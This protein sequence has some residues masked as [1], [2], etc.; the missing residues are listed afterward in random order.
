MGPATCIAKERALPQTALAFD[1]E[2]H[3]IAPGLAAPPLVCVSWA[4]ADR[5]GLFA[6][7]E[8]LRFLHAALVD[9]DFL[10]IGHN[11]AY[12]MAVLCAAGGQPMIDAVFTA[13]AADR[14]R[15]TMIRAMLLSIARGTFAFERKRMGLAALGKEHL[16]VDLDKGE[17]TWR[18][19]YSELDNMPIAVWPEEARAYALRDGRTTFDLFTALP[20]TAS[21]FDEG[22]QVR[23]A[24]ALQ[25]MTVW[26]LRTDPVAVQKLEARL[27]GEQQHLL[28]QLVPTGWIRAT[29]VK[30]TKVLRD[31]VEAQFAVQGIQ[32]PRTAPSK[33]FPG[34]QIKINEETLQLINDPRFEPF[35]K[36]ERNKKIL[37]TFIPVVRRGTQ[38]P[39]NPR[40][41][42]AE[43]GRTTCSKGEV[44]DRAGKKQIVGANVQQLPRAKGVR[45]CFVPRPGWVFGAADWNSAELCALA[46]VMFSW[47][48]FSKM[49]IAI[50]KGRDLHVDLASELL[51]VS[52]EDAMVRKAAGDE[53]IKD[54]RQF[55]KIGNFGLAGGMGARTFVIHARGKGHRTTLEKAEHLKR[56]WK[57]KWGMNPYFD[58]IGELTKETGPC[59]IVQYGSGR[60][61]GRLNFPQ[62]ANTFFQGLVADAAK[63][64]LFAVAVAC[65]HDRTSPMY[66][67]RPVVFAH[68]EVI[69]E[70]PEAQAAAATDELSRIMNAEGQRWM[71]DVPITSEPA[72]M[73]RW[74]KGAK[75]IRDAQGVL[76]VYE[77]E[78][79]T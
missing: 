1:T 57:H 40:Y 27:R 44:K 9:P 42:M 63:T 36:Y 12:D 25:L 56:T 66:G 58:A 49:R 29:G 30:D 15:D 2:T 62:A 17:D 78:E 79:T 22:N 8:G 32:A 72:L 65:Y 18:M 38:V 28:A 55:S 73:R 51:G 53:E 67:S 7:E 43:T 68:D 19:R 69:I 3:L 16:G 47:F 31:Y 14:V 50:Q 24:F 6:R 64:M 70:A 75:T 23:A 4:T 39:L 37:G 10:I 26:G 54:A 45:D 71:P 61:R 74:I 52:Y 20:P 48:G 76:Q 60:V 11:V 34:G 59:R 46:Q 35:L 13:Y 33:K 41:G 77:P 21:D 5:V